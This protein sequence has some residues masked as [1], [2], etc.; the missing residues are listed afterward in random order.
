MT[1]KP[2]C[3]CAW[4]REMT[5]GQL[6]DLIGQH[7]PQVSDLGDHTDALPTAHGFQEYWGSLA[8]L[9]LGLSCSGAGKQCE[10]RRGKDNAAHCLP[11]P[12]LTLLYTFSIFSPF[13]AN[14]E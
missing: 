5:V 12:L 6:L 9:G 1:V 10:H 4:V 2:V 14:L 11:Q 8:G 7:E 13:V 3:D